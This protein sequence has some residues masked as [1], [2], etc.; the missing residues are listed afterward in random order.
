MDKTA[1]SVKQNSSLSFVKESIFPGFYTHFPG[2][3]YRRQ[4]NEGTSSLRGGLRWSMIRSEYRN[5]SPHQTLNVG[6]CVTLVFVKGKHH[7]AG[8]KWQAAVIE[9]CLVGKCQVHSSQ[10]DHL[11]CS[12]SSGRCL[13]MTRLLG[14]GSW[15]TF[16]IHL[17]YWADVSSVWV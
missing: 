14:L 5:K 15:D 1:H 9:L 16:Y 4:S 10:F 13:L 12:S 7:W 2:E 11:D 17:L 6:P 3:L 8:A